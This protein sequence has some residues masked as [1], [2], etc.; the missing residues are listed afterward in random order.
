MKKFIWAGVAAALVAGTI[1]AVAG[2]GGGGTKYGASIS[3]SEQVTRV[4][5][6]NS[7]PDAYAG[8]TVVINGYF[9][10]G[11]CSDCFLVKDG[12]ASMRVVG[13]TTVPVPPSSKIN[14]PIRVIGSVEVKEGTTPGEKAL[15][16]KATGLE[17]D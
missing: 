17:L 10:Q 1:I 12:T 14:S 13:S 9:A 2:C 6:I 3:A 8:K 16:I 5:D 7:N 15:S 4:A 11:F